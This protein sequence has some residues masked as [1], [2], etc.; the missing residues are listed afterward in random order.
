LR[1]AAVVRRMLLGGAGLR[2]RLQEIA[3]R[4]GASLPQLVREAGRYLREMVPGNSALGYRLLIRFS[5]FFYQRGYDRQILCDPAEIERLRVLISQHP[6]ALISNHRSQVDGFAVYCALHDNRLPHPFAF[7]GINM[8]LPVMGPILKGSGLVFLR[9][10]FQ[11][12]PVYKAVLRS[13]IDFLTEHRFPLLW[14]IEG[15]R[16]RTGKLAAPRFGLLSWVLNA[17]HQSAREDLQVVPVALSY[18]QIADVQAFAAEQRGA[19]KRPENFRWLLRYL[20]SLSRPMGSIAVRFG[21]AVSVRE[22]IQ[23]LRSEDPQLLAHPEKILLRIVIAACVQLNEATP[24]TAPSLVCLVLLQAVPRAVTRRELEREFLQLCGYVESHRWPTTLRPAGQPLVSLE[25]ALRALAQGGVIDCFGGGYEP[26]Y[27]IVPGQELGAAYY[28]NNSIHF[29]VTGAVAELALGKALAHHDPA[30]RQATFHAEVLHLRQLF[31][32]E[33]YFPPLP[34]LFERIDAD[35]DLRCPA[36]RALLASPDAQPGRQ[37]RDVSPLLCHGVLE[38][39]IEAYQVVAEH[40]VRA[41]ADAPCDTQALLDHCL[42]EAE[43]MYRLRR[44]THAE[45]VAKPMLESGLLAARSRGLL[46]GGAAAEPLGAKRRA[47]CDELLELSTRLRE[48]R[49]IASVRRASR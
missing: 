49:H 18:E 45:T 11:D 48:I 4:S 12:N 1:N 3:T 20:G 24:V 29:F 19:R 38:C 16:S 13:Y 27:S 28:R 37:L 40:L 30:V 32:F 41:T 35:L 2:E 10:S 7:G 17:E 21:Q 9:R 47:Y 42:G 43:Q 26:V 25:R 34:L 22:Q 44:I 6:V 36:W 39:F 23:R 15:T 33:F 46:D 5:R 8:K 14:A 31:K